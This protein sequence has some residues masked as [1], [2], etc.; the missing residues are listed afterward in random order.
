MAADKLQ[1]RLGNGGHRGTE[2]MSEKEMSLPQP[3][4]DTRTT[5]ADGVRGVLKG[6]CTEQASAMFGGWGKAL[7]E[8]SGGLPGV[9][10]L[11]LGWVSQV[12]PLFLLLEGPTWTLL[13]ECVR[14][15]SLHC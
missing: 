14:K 12:Q 2:K 9:F 5:K 15:G 1:G 3:L 6:C 8:T 7:G 4:I 13:R 11:L 10:W